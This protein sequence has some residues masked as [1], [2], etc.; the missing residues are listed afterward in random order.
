MA[1]VTP[2]KKTRES[3]IELYRIVL[4]LLIIAHHYVV[5]SGITAGF[6]Y[7]HIDMQMIGF[8]VFGGWGKTGINCFL[9]IT[10]YFMYRQQCT[11]MKF[12]KLILEI[13]FYKL[14]IYGIF[15]VLGMDALSFNRLYSTLFNVTKNFGNGF[16]PTF[17]CLFLLIPYI[18]K[19]ISSLSRSE[20]NRLLITL[21][22]LFS[23][24]STFVLNCYFEYLGWY[25][26]VYLIGAY[27]AKYPFKWM[28]SLRSATYACVATWGLGTLSIVGL[29]YGHNYILALTH[30]KIELSIFYFVADSNRILSIICAVTLFV[31]FLNIKMRP[32][33]VINTVAMATFGV[34]LIHGHSDV[35]RQ[36]LWEDTLDNVGHM[37]S[38]YAWLHA[39][40]SVLVVYVVCVNIDLLRIFLI[41]R[42]FFKWMGKKWPSLYK[43]W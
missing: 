1:E 27:I 28:Q 4:M 15:V 42:P 39:I 37:Y 34:L 9:L 30:G 12:L 23:V 29:L 26:T 13:K 35:M 14:L 5:N 8:A 7:S 18:N 24:I 36:W 33:R 43:K 11:W 21:L 10:G 25:V 32:N 41:E 38:S 3:N 16:V 40:G 22:T 19:L 2:K 17:V 20:Y 31:L 6:N